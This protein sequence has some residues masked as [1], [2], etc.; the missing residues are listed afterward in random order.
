[1]RRMIIT[2][3]YCVAGALNRVKVLYLKTRFLSI[4]SNPSVEEVALGTT[5]FLLRVCVIP[6]ALGGMD[7]V[8][9]VTNVQFIC[10]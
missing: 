8:V 2:V 4:V 1:M 6:P 3:L 5:T 9:S 7:S 10:G